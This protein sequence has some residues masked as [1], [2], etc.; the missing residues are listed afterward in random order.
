M[1]PV[2]R[3]LDWNDCQRIAAEHGD[4]F[5]LLDQAR[6]RSNAS[7]LRGQFRSR[8]PRSELA[9]AYKAN[10]L[11]VVCR[12]LAEMGL[13]ADVACERE[14]HQALAVGVPP[15]RVVSNGPARGAPDLAAALRAGSIVNL[16]SP[17][18]LRLAREVA[19]ASPG[20][21]FPVGLR[22]SFPVLDQAGSR[23]GLDVDGPEFA[24]AVGALRGHQG[25]RLAGLHCHFADRRVESFAYRAAKLVDVASQVIPAG[26]DYL[27]FGGNIYG[28]VPAQLPGQLGEPP[29]FADYAEAV[30]AAMIAGYGVGDD[31]PTLIIEP[32]A[33]IVATAVRFI[34]RVISV[35]HSHGRRIATVHGS[36]LNISPNTRRMDFP[37]RLLSAGG[38]AST[39][40]GTLCDVAG[41]SPMEGDYL[42]LGV[43]LA[44]SEGDFLSFARV[45]AY[46]IS[47][48]PRALAPPAAVLT[49]RA[50]GAPWLPELDVPGTCVAVAPNL[51]PGV[52]ARDA[53]APAAGGR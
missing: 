7:S 20:R 19:G 11:P 17:R 8:Y 29:R 2:S 38:E 50:A 33:A 44:V 43:P 32:G 25:L 6:L 14:R 41:G 24:D 52:D 35:K 34:T 48:A 3:R 10:D 5:F 12:A 40:P 37:V 36:L 18:D 16:D 15:E 9:Y 47:M 26:P 28:G 42:A 4:S 22:C 45:G 30:T 46:S 53:A 23:F 51:Q 13:L 1:N 27:D 31:S 49:R 21:S 39:G